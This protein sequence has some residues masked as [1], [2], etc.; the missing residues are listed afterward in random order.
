MLSGPE[1]QTSKPPV[2][3]IGNRTCILQFATLLQGGR[4][5]STPR[6][7]LHCELRTT[8]LSYRHYYLRALLA[9]VKQNAGMAVFGVACLSAQA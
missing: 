5:I 6:A 8:A 9:S 2:I 3:R 4:W 7:C 1:S